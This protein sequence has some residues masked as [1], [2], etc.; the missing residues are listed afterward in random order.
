MKT[1]A[2]HLP[3]VLFALVLLALAAPAG[4]Q[5]SLVR[6]YPVLSGDT[7]LVRT[8]NSTFVTCCN[9]TGW[10]SCFVVDDGTT[11]RRFFTTLAPS[12]IHITDSGYVV[13]DMQLVN[14][15]CWFAG[16]KWFDTGLPFYTLD[17]QAYNLVT[18]KAVIGRFNTADVLNGSGNY[19]IIEVSGLHHI[20]RLAVIGSNV[21]AIGVK[22][23]GT[24]QL[25]ELYKIPFF[26][27]YIMTTE[28][29]SLPQEVFMDVVAAG[30]KM[31]LL[32]RFSTPGSTELTNYF[33]LRYG[34]AGLLFGNTTL[35]RHD[36]SPA[37]NSY[38]TFPSVHPMRLAATNNGNGVV[39]AYVAQNDGL[40]SGN[41]WLY[42]FVLFHIAA[43][44]DTYTDVII[45][46][47]GEKYTDIADLRF[48]KPITTN[49]H[50]SL[51]LQAGPSDVYLRFP[52][53]NFSGSTTDVILYTTSPYIQSVAPYQTAATGL[54]LA[55]AGHHVLTN[56]PYTEEILEEDILSLTGTSYSNN[57]LQT[58]EGML[59]RTSVN[60]RIG[61]LTCSLDTISVKRSVQFVNHSYT[62]SIISKTTTCIDG[63]H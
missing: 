9:T 25:V 49:T 63:I 55:A 12:G 59:S 31:V 22:P 30:N 44:N 2:L 6:Q 26:N 47:D 57:C 48:N 40:P 58:S 15:V 11:C 61:D 8:D 56:T 16:Y 29:S 38:L 24:R 34:T 3:K 17:G 60:S 39:V 23:N 18:Y 5:N 46:T 37:Y 51:L 28:E 50:M 21:T 53:L 13:Y 33:G 1:I 14:G 20:E 36:V 45:N 7:V 10:R 35:H 19:G 43:E 42:K 4:G 54:E 27:K 62:S 32:S 52:P 41:P